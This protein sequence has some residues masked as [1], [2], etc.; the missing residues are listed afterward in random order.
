M[1]RN[2]PSR[3]RHEKCVKSSWQQSG[4]QYGRRARVGLQGRLA[5]SDLAVAGGERSSWKNSYEFLS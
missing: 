1:P 5:A 4:Q 2:R 3:P